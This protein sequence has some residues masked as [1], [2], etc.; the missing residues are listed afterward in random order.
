GHESKRAREHPM[1]RTPRSLLHWPLR[2]IV[3]LACLL[4]E[5]PAGAQDIAAAEALFDKGVADMKAGRHETG[6]KAIAE[7][8]RL[9]PRPGTL[10]TLA[11]CEA[12]WGRIATAV[13]RYGDYLAVYARLPDDKKAA[14]LERFKV[15]TE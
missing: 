1:R 8:Q 2:T 14:Q 15:A 9:D 10:F 4:A 3:L 7:S 11:T 12:A 6:C 13:S 5:R